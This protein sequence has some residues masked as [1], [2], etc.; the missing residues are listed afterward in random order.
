MLQGLH[1]L[2]REGALEGGAHCRHRVEHV[3]AALMEACIDLAVRVD[4]VAELVDPAALG[5]GGGSSGGNLQV[6]RW[7]GGAGLVNQVGSAG[8]R[9][10]KGLVR[11]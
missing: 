9:G 10:M 7:G 2:S 6:G 5:V 11:S 1:G 4:D 3:G 8:S